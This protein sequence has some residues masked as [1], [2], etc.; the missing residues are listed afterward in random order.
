MDLMEYLQRNED[1]FTVYQ[2]ITVVHP[3]SGILLPNSSA[4]NG[5]T[6]YGLGD[7]V[8]SPIDS[9]YFVNQMLLN[10]AGF[11]SDLDS[12][13]QVRLG[14]AGARNVYDNFICGVT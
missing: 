10:L 14:S 12:F 7:V 2:P 6:D 8:V 9:Y 5:N 13:L 4:F 3:T 11:G 1:S